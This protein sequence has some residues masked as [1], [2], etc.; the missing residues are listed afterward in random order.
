MGVYAQVIFLAVVPGDMR[1]HKAFCGNAV[2]ILYGVKAVVAAVD[3]YVVNVQMQAAVGFFEHGIEKLEFAEITRRCG[4]GGHVFH[5]DA[6][7]EY[8]LHAA[9]PLCDVV[10]GLLGEGYWHEV[11]ELAMVAAI[12]QV[13]GVGACTMPV[14]KHLERSQKVIVERCRAPNRQRQAVADQRVALGEEPQRLAACAPNIDPVLRRDLDKADLRRQ[15]VAHLVD[16]FHAQP[17][18]RP[19]YRETFERRFVQIRGHGGQQYLAWAPPL[20]RRAG[21]AGRRGRR[22]AGTP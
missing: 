2:E 8:L 16:Q 1:I 14:E 11:V 20:G 18:T 12:R 15:S 5:T 9:N 4:V 6:A 17:Q 7:F 10:H 21:I 13:F 22:R 3:E 19:C